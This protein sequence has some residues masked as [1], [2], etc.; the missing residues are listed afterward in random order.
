MPDSDITAISSIANPSTQEFIFKETPK[1]ATCSAMICP[2]GHEWTP[3]LEVTAC[4]GCKSPLL[5]LKMN[6]C[7]Q[8]NEPSKLIKLRLDHLPK[9]G[10]LTPICQGSASLAECITLELQFN[11]FHETEKK[12]KD[13][14]MP[15]KI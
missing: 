2:N 5:A 14:E 10:A 4:P 7:P 8:C 11:H 1:V 15:T 12:H 13:R 6:Q 3:V 9:G